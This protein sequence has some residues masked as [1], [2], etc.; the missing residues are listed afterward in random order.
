MPGPRGRSWLFMQCTRSSLPGDI[1]QPALYFERIKMRKTLAILTLLTVC[2]GMWPSSVFGQNRELPAQAT[3]H[4][5][6]V[7][8]PVHRDTSS[9]PLREMFDTGA[10]QKPARGGRDFEP[11]RPDSA[12][13]ANPKGIDPL[14]GKSVGSP[15][16]FADPKASTV[17]TPVDPN[18]RVAPP[19]TTGDLGPNHYVQWVNLR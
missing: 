5:A 8:Y 9:R 10:P 3:D 11:G 12:G 4:R 7:S 1:K 18:F 2:M 13:N 16:T 17:G 6:E 15:N 19:D 14:A